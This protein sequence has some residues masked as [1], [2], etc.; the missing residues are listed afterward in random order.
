M[1]AAEFHRRRRYIAF[2]EKDEALFSLAVLRAFPEVIFVRATVPRQPT[3]TYFESL[4]DSGGASVRII[5]ADQN[6]MPVWREDVDWNRFAIENPVKRTFKYSR[7]KWYWGPADVAHRWSWTPPTLEMGNIE[8]EYHRDDAEMKRFI[9]QVLKIGEK[10]STNRLADSHD[11]WQRSVQRAGGGMV[12]AGHH[13][14]TWCREGERRML[15]G[16]RRPCIDW[17]PPTTPWHSALNTH[18]EEWRQRWPD[19]RVPPFRNAPDD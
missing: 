12:W 7:S 17:E 15:L 10:L 1:P 3:Y 14:L 18:F 4:C 9:R 13:A 19:G 2:N 8:F 5:V 6:W 11:N 16:N